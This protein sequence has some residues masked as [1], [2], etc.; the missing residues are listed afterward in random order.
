MRNT[1]YEYSPYTTIRPGTTYYNRY[2]GG[3][4]SRQGSARKDVLISSFLCLIDRYLIGKKKKNLNDV[5]E[6]LHL[7]NLFL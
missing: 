4:K 3:I 7:Y 6:Q 1:E 2:F 5:R